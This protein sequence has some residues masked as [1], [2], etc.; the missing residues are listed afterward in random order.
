[1]AIL[2]CAE[3]PNLKLGPGVK[4]GDPDIIEFK[5]GYAEVDEND[6]MFAEKLSWIVYPGTPLIR[7][8]EEDEAPLTDP[9]AVRCPECGKPF[10]TERKLSGHLMSHRR[11]G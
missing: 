8:L 9:N 5:D 10:A 4:P 3:T 11:K 6:P 1:M 7:V 2:Y